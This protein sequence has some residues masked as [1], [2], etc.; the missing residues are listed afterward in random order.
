MATITV[1]VI[2]RFGVFFADFS[3]M[4]EGSMYVPFQ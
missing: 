1:H 2:L 4:A 3:D